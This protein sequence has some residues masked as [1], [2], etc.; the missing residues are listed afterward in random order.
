MLKLKK[1][2]TSAFFIVT[3][4]LA[5]VWSTAVWS[6][7]TE[8]SCTSDSPLQRVQIDRV[9]DG[10]TVRLASGRS[11]RLLGIN[12]PELNKST[13]QPEPFARQALMALQNLAQKT[14]AEI[15]IGVDSQDHYKR[16][17]AH[18]FFDDL[19]AAQHLLERGLGWAVVIEPN[20][21]MA[22]CLFAAERSARDKGEGIWASPI[23]RASQV[24]SG[25]FTLVRGNVTRIDPTP[26]YIYLELD[27]H[28]AL[29]LTRK[30]F[31]ANQIVAVGNSLGRTIEARG[32]VVDRRS[33]LKPGSA[34][35][36]FLLS[37]GSRWHL[38]LQQ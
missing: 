18:L 30:H 21:E 10:D 33:K 22:D 13:G 27:D 6:A 11:V 24:S 9:V 17:L 8:Q 28:L 12:T 25:G 34:Y 15:A 16:L 36:G 37:I 3:F 23:Q 14:K 4:C 32:W 7:S 1:A 2:L 29:R 20:I 38:D 19:N 31:P 26:K 5:G 35:K